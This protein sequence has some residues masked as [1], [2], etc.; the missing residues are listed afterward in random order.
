[1]MLG[2]V[3]TSLTVTLHQGFSRVVLVYSLVVAIWALFLYLS[4]SNPSGSY[5]GAAVINEGVVVVQGLIGLVL[6]AQ[7]D[8]PHEGLHL[9]YG[10]ISVLA[11]PTAYFMSANA[12]QRR[13]SLLFGF[14][15]LVLVGAS[16]RA[17]MT[18]TA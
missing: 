11:L 13:D 16:I 6:L 4:G 3:H 18:G 1:M 7:G 9:V 2:V 14:A 12:T 5:L 17:I 8:R 10:I 15:G